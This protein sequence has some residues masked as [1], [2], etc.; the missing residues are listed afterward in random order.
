[1]I[2]TI[3]EIDINF[4]FSTETGGEQPDI[5]RD[6]TTLRK[7]HKLL[8]IKKLP[9]GEVPILSE[10]DNNGLIIK[11]DTCELILSSDTMINTYTGNWDKNFDLRYLKTI[12]EIEGF[13]NITHKIGNFIMYP[14]TKINDMNSF[15]QER[16]TNS[17]IKDRFDLSLECIKRYYQNEDSPL[18]ETIQ[19]YNQFFQLF[20]NFKSYCEY[21]FLEDLTINNYTEIKY[22]LPFNNFDEMPIPK[23]AEE[24]T[25]YMNKA[26]EFINNRNKRIQDFINNY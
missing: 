11:T 2:K 12:A 17:K 26:T 14:R 4:D 15:N 6:S 16:G 1:M 9:N 3:K 13:V 20:K 7:Y 21:Y 24:Y 23:N 5:E 10:T 8:W 25:L 19:R 18:R 22:F